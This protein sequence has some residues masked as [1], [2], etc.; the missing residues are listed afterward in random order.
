MLSRVAVALLVLLLGITPAPAQQF[1]T[2]VPPATLAVTAL[3]AANTAVTATLPAVAERFHYITS[4]RVMRTCTTAITGSANLTVTS[5][6]LPGSVAWMSG[7]ACAVGTTNEI[8]NDNYTAAPL[9]SSVLNTATTIVCPALGAAGL[10]Q[11]T[12]LYYTGP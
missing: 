10:C 5:T 4:L 3:S 11:I 2:G 1:V 8:V 12:V 9:R 7:N 6:N